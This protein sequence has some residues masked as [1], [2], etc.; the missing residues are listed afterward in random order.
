MDTVYFAENWEK[1]IV[2][3]LG[4][5]HRPKITVMDNEQCQTRVQGKKQKNKKR[6]ARNAI[7]KRHLSVLIASTNLHRIQSFFLYLVF[8]Y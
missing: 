4:T 6:N 1:N 2:H 8:N 3:A 7:P 5:V